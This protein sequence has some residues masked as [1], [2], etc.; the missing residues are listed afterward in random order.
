MKPT[1][2]SRKNKRPIT[3]DEFNSPNFS[4]RNGV[5]IKRIILHYTTSRNVRGVLSWF[6]NPESQVSAHYVIAT[7]GGIFWVVGEDMKAWH[8]YGENADSIGIEICAEKGDK[9]TAEQTT[10]LVALLRYLLEEYH[11]DETAITAH[12]FTAANK[13]RTDC[14]GDLW[15]SEAE[16]SNWV[17]ANVREWPEEKPS[18]PTSRGRPYAPCPVPVLWNGPLA[19]G[20]HGPTVYQLQCALIGLGYLAKPKD[21]EL[22]GD[23]FNEHVEYAVRRFQTD[24]GFV[25]E[26]I[27]GIVGPFTRQHIEAALKVA[28]APKPPVDNSVATLKCIEGLWHEGAWA[29]LKVLNLGIGSETFRVA[30]GARGA[31]VLR[32]PQDPRSTPGNLEPIPQGR[33]RIGDIQFANGKDNYEGSFGAGLGPVWVGLDADFSDDRGAFGFHLDSNIGSS[34]GSAGCVVFR[35]LSDLKRFVAALRKHDPK[36]LDV[37]WKL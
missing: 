19:L 36:V 31:Q 34:P 1:G 8:A 33:Y 12:R 10:T 23:V 35:D 3:N 37:N 18:E 20:A 17:R 4:S 30:S 28:R 29:G 6:A 26:D 25:P 11:L 13:G 14:P 32:R 2:T 5:A 15:K 9:L 27:D 7:D 22:V 16:L 24:R 21:G